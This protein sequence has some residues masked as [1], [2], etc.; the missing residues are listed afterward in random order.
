MFTGTL[1]LSNLQGHETLSYLPD[2][3]VIGLR[4]GVFSAYLVDSLAKDYLLFNRNSTVRK[5]R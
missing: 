2:N 3:R 1:L 4:S 5:K